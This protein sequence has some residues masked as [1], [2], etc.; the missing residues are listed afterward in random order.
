MNTTERWLLGALIGINLVLKCAWLG[1]N[2]LTLDEPFTVYW[3]Q[4]PWKE[5]WAM[6]AT[7]NNP[8][9]FFLII[10]CW[11]F[12][13]PFEAAWLR[14][15]SA[16]FS[17]LTVWPLFL[18]ARQLVD[19][20]TAVLAC[21]L[22]TFSNYHYGFAHEVR[23]YAFFTL[24]T[25]AAMWVLIRTNDTW[26]TAG[27]ATLSILL[28][29]THFFGWLVLGLLGSLTL[30]PELRSRRRSLFTAL[31]ITVVAFLPYSML[32]AQR[33]GQSVSEGTWLT[34]PVP[35]ELYN[36]VWRWSNAPVL[37][38]LFLGSILAACIKDRLRSTALRLG[39]V[40][41]FVPLV[42]MFLVS[43]QVPIFLDRYL[44]YAAPGFALLVA[45]SVVNLLP[46]SPAR[47]VLAGLPAVGLLLTFTPWKDNG[48]HPSRVVQ[49]ETTWC[50][51]ACS[52]E[53]LPPWYWLTHLAA[54]DIRS[55]QRPAQQHMAFSNGD[56]TGKGGM[57]DQPGTAIVI[58][59]GAELVDPTRAWYTRL[60]TTH[61]QVDS[62]E[63]THKVWIYRFRR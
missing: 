16:L 51:G 8:P 52:V 6:F 29:Y 24:L 34:P 12:F 59:A 7:E 61:P 44:V 31:G 36:M 26:R 10:R 18:L 45:T 30:L 39:L 38:V 57:N 42:G 21:L 17:A 20:R 37:A 1:V 15:P 11:S 5:M 50:D 25:T 4:R 43:Y 56:Q 23:A 14:A 33:L 55:L 41:T 2:E 22:F 27:L 62:V 35:E 40:W 60:K 9:L 58:D 28:V 32:F 53:V 63:A 46:S 47:N 49:L 13:T 3:S 48:L 19:R 54:T